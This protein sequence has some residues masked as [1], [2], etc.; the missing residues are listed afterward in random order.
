[1]KI[2]IIDCVNQDLGLKILFPEADYFINNDEEC[3][4]IDRI[5]SYSYY[6]INVNKDWSK[7][8]DKNYDC[9]FAIIP[10]YD[11]FP[12]KV[13]YKPNIHN[14][15]K[16]KGKTIDYQMDNKGQVDLFKQIL[17]GFLTLDKDYEI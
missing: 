14:I 13:F 8:N 7:I 6:N 2:A 9:L 10:L 3:T 11:A 1:M 17:G 16:T 15:Y 12:E 5:K 4:I